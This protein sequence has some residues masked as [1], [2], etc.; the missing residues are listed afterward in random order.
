MQRAK[1]IVKQI[2]LVEDQNDFLL[3]FKI[4]IEEFAKKGRFSL[5]T[6]EC[7]N[8]H[9][10]FAL[11]NQG[12][13]PDLIISDYQMPCM[14]GLDLL[15]DLKRSGDP[16]L[17]SIPF[18]MASGDSLVKDTAIAQGAFSFLSKIQISDELV[19]MIKRAL[20]IDPM[21]FV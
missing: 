3:L 8:G 14:D 21:A 20:R 10:A 13:R 2:L 17:N 18:I 19:P 9:E 7:K 6:V 1:N 4:C 16:G 11:L 12:L 15:S 5:E